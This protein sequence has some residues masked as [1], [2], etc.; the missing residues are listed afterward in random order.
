MVDEPVEDPTAGRGAAEG[1][2]QGGRERVVHVD[3]GGHRRVVPVGGGRV[4]QELV[5]VLGRGAGAGGRV[6]GAH[7]LGDLVG[8][9]GA[10]G[11]RSGGHA[12]GAAGRTRSTVTQRPCMTPL[13][14]SVLLAQRRLALVSSRTIAM[15]SS[16]VEVAS[17]CSTSACGV[18][19]I[20]C[21]PR[22]SC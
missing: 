19:V 6:G 5:G 18:V 13:V 16:A 11:D 1:L 17:A 10:A 21:L 9:G 2:T 3:V 7:Q 15:Q 14:V 4:A 12:R 20:S 22:R 8:G